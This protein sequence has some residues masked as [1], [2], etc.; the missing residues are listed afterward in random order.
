[1]TQQSEAQ[2]LAD[3]LDMTPTPVVVELRRLEGE[4][5]RKSDAI[6]RLWKE[7]DDLRAV[8]AQLLEVLENA[9]AHFDVA[10]RFYGQDKPAECAEGCLPKQICD[11]CQ[12]VSPVRAMILAERDAR[13]KVCDGYIGADP[14][15]SAIRA[16]GQV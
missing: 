3:A 5:E 7:R 4:S 14:I 13:A 8:N 12:V 1:M 2:R 16:R 6:Q 11:Y 10:K 15:A 9:I